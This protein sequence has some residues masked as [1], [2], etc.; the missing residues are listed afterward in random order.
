MEWVAAP[1]LVLDVILLGL[2]LWSG[3]LARLL[4]DLSGVLESCRR[5]GAV[6]ALW[7]VWLATTGLAIVSFVDLDRSWLGG[8]SLS[9]SFCAAFAAIAASDRVMSRGPRR[10]R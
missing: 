8:V 3:A 4:R 9:V 2:L 1:I 6:V 10:E 5:S 7:C